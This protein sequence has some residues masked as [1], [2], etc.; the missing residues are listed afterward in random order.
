MSSDKNFATKYAS[1]VWGAATSAF[2]VIS[3]L[4]LSGNLQLR[5]FPAPHSEPSGNFIFDY[6]ALIAGF[7]AL[8]G[9]A[10]TVQAI[11][12]QI[13]ASRAIEQEKIERKHQALKA[14][15]PLYSTHIIHYLRQSFSRYE[16]ILNAIEPQAGLPTSDQIAFPKDITDFLIE[17]ISYADSSGDDEIGAIVSNF[18][19]QIQI[20][21]SRLNEN[22]DGRIDKKIKIVDDVISTAELFLET[23]KLFDYGRG[24]Y[25]SYKSMNNSYEDIHSTLFFEAK[26]MLDYDHIIRTKCGNRMR[27]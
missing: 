21:N 18:L 19:L 23:K 17:F 22:I 7:F 25:Y 27:G 12:K 26:F 24:D 1:F 15:L 20:H 8:I 13:D 2:C 11:F 6:Q 3:L 14:A 4:L 5:D 16:T 10:W 9:A